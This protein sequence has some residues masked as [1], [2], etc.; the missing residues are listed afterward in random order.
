VTSGLP[1]NATPKHCHS[2]P[3]RAVLAVS[4]LPGFHWVIPEISQPQERHGD[5]VCVPLRQSKDIGPMGHAL[6]RRAN[7][8]VLLVH[9]PES[10]GVGVVPRF[11]KCVFKDKRRR[12]T[13]R[14]RL[15]CNASY[16]DA[17]ALSVAL[18]PGSSGRPELL[19]ARPLV[20]GV[21]GAAGNL[22]APCCSG[23]HRHRIDVQ[24]RS[25]VIGVVSNVR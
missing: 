16:W 3:V 10:A 25:E 13:R 20:G 15:T 12:P 19:L 8:P 4:W 22:P 11:W 5:L 24:P 6:D 21:A 14:F 2:A 1:T 18:C 7:P 17:P 23:A 9:S